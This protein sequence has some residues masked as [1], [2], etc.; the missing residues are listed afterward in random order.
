MK[1]S[2][3][4]TIFFYSIFP[5]S[6][7]FSSNLFFKMAAN[8]ADMQKTVAGKKLILVFWH[9]FFPTISARLHEHLRELFFSKWPPIWPPCKKPSMIKNW[10]LI[11]SHNFL[12]II[13]ARLHKHLRQ[14]SFPKRPPVRPPFK[15]YVLLKMFSY[16]DTICLQQKWFHL[17]GTPGSVS[18]AS[19][20]RRP[21]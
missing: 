13:S 5:T 10:N 17:H 11:F 16:F 18:K 21:C 19:F 8:M 20:Y 9:N 7:T 15:R 3:F 14:F 2:Y 1:F 12:P 4:D 6:R